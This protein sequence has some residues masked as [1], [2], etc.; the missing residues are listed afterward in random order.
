MY[1]IAVVGPEQ[2]VN[3]ILEIAKEFEQ[4]LTFIPYIYKKTSEV[5]EFVLQPPKWSI[6]GCFQVIFLIKLR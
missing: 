3:R 5:K 6:I 1:K 4:D 2:S